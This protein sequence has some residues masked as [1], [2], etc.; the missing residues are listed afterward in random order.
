MYFTLC[1]WEEVHRLYLTAHMVHSSTQNLLTSRHW[2]TFQ[3]V[4][5]AI[6]TYTT[7]G[8]YFPTNALKD[9]GGDFYSS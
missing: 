2:K 7:G 5:A 3:W 4:R 6:S 1:I 8:N 9:H